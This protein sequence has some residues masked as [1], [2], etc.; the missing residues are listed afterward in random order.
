MA[1]PFNDVGQPWEGA[2][3][4]QEFCFDLVESK[5]CMRSPSTN[6]NPGA[7]YITVCPKDANFRVISLTMVL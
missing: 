2:D 3:L 5:M 4:G 6:A 7:E 1:T